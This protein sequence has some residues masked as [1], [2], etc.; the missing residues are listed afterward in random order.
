[1][2]ASLRLSGSRT[3]LFRVEE[4]EHQL[5][6]LLN[7]NRP[8]RLAARDAVCLDEFS[9]LAGSKWMFHE[10]TQL[11]EL[12]DA[13][14]LITRPVDQDT[15][16]PTPGFLA[17]YRFTAEEGALC[18]QT[19]LYC[20]ETLLADSLS[21]LHFEV[22]KDAFDRLELREPRYALPIEQ[23]NHSMRA[24]ELTLSGVAG[25]LTFFDCGQAQF[26]PANGYSE[27]CEPARA[28]GQAA[29]CRQLRP[30]M[31]QGERALHMALS[32]EE[33]KK[34][35]AVRSST[36][37][38]EALGQQIR[39][40]SGSLGLSFL[41]REDGV[42]PLGIHLSDFT[43][44]ENFSLLPLMKLT[45]QRLAD[46]ELSTVT[47][48][49]GWKKV[50]A[51]Q[52][53]GLLSF[54]MEEPEDVPGLALRVEAAADGK[55]RITWRS[56]VLNN[57]TAYSVLYATYPGVSCMG[58]KETLLT[59]AFCGRLEKNPFQND[60]HESNPYPA[61]CA[62]SLPLYAF[63]DPA[64]KKK[65]G[66]YI[67]VHDDTGALK[68]MRVDCFDCG[69]AAVE[70]RYGAIN[71]GR[72][73]NAFAL[74]GRMILQV[75]D[76]DW[77]DAAD[78]YR[79][80]VQAQAPWLPRKGRPDSPQW[81]QDTPLYL[82]D[83]M[84]NDNPDAD[85]VPI[86]IR[87]AV[88]PPR[89]AWVQK[90]IRLA[91]R[92]HNVPI[93]YH[94]YNWHWIPFNNDYPHYFPVK[95]G[96][97]EGVDELKRHNVRTMPYI[98]GRLWDTLDN[99]GECGEFAQAKADAT[100]SWNGSLFLESYASHEPDGQLCRL[101]AM[102]PSSAR[103]RNTLDRVTRR[104][105]D[106][107]GMSAVYIDQIAAAQPNLCADETHLHMPGNGGWWRESY[108]LL[109]RQ[110]RDHKPKDCGFTSEA[111]AETYCDQFDGFLSWTWITA[112]LAP[113]FVRIYAGY[114][115]ML[116]RN[117][118]GYKKQDVD[119][120]RYHV[121]QSVLWGQQIGWINADVVDDEEK[122][123]FLEP[124]VAMRYQLRQ[125]FTCGDLLRSPKIE[126]KIPQYV[127]DTGMG[128]PEM[129]VGDQYQASAWRLNN[130]ALVMAVNL[131]D[132]PAQYTMML[133]GFTPG[134]EAA[135][136]AGQGSFCLSGQT[137][138]VT[139][140]PHSAIAVELRIL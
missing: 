16:A 29:L 140:E 46:G 20:P 49:R 70:F 86:S 101:A 135:K 47:T 5:V 90:P 83:W 136:I 63:Y 41:V 39:L 122:M 35:Q 91:D 69:Q 121:A 32:F 84:P 134:A 34:T 112:T 53:P 72:P 18:V 116:G 50:K 58:E 61:G 109:M 92:L 56:E 104:L 60:F 117:T 38:K 93:G 13:V 96:L 88:E 127:T 62:Y 76:G 126:G 64:R 110:L 55:G 131:T 99:R 132:R 33:G 97:R 52:E 98:N 37:K 137:M 36:A 119:Y 10:K 6:V 106:E 21:W 4:K 107:Y 65:N 42:T 133:Q 85:P 118:N 43:P 7:H 2:E 3:V 75:F 48:E 67:A 108:R 40:A 114:I 59:P 138:Q 89:D 105:F 130:Q 100:K 8:I 31:F 115:A 14:E 80:F 27:K 74:T 125:Y 28:F 123:A 45:L 103:W 102:C 30:A 22:E 94:L 24:G 95:T 25:T 79:E 23:V 51:C 17:I 120:F 87:P 128:M 54:Y 77:Y 9:P 12:Q 57:N 111:T 44:V 73:A 124:M 19:E 66:L 11:K 71:M 26:E 81:M 15:G 129:F 139:L 78:I 113:V 1:M 82:M 68:D